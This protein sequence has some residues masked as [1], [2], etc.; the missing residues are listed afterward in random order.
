MSQPSQP[1]QHNQHSQ[2]EDKPVYPTVNYLNADRGVKSWLLTLDYKR[3]AI[4]YLASVLVM[5]LVWFLARSL[6][7]V[8]PIGLP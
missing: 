4:M 2:H 3:I 7:Y 5:F 1:S 6:P 8:P